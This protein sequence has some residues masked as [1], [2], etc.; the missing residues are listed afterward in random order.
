MLFFIKKKKTRKRIG[1]NHIQAS[2]EQTRISQAQ[3]VSTPAPIQPP[4]IAAIT[5][6][7]QFCTTQQSNKS[8]KQNAN[9]SQSDF[10]FLSGRENQC[11]DDGNKVWIERYKREAIVQQI[12]LDRETQESKNICNL[13]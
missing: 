7:E 13:R 3:I 12:G 11:L 6:L 8:E 4:C 10:L 9:G 1:R 5:G 2:E